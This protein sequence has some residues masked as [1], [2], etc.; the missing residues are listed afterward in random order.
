MRRILRK[1]A[2]NQS[3]ELGDISTLANPSVVEHIIKKHAAK[4]ADS[5]VWPAVKML[6]L[7]VWSRVAFVSLT[8]FFYGYDYG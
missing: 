5:R 8:G 3:E 1:I 2:A 4:S 6:N 7:Y